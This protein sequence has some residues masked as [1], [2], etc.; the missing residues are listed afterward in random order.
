MLEYR[1]TWCR[2]S[3]QGQSEIETLILKFFIEICGDEMLYLKFKSN[4]PEQPFKEQQ[5]NFMGN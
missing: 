3:A 4:T 1:L 5:K 2:K